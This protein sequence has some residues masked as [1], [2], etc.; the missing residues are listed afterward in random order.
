MP[1]KL[2]ILAEDFRGLH[3]SLCKDLDKVPNQATIALFYTLVNHLT[4][5]RSKYSNIG[6]LFYLTNILPHSLEPLQ[7]VCVCTRHLAA[8][9]YILSVGFRWNVRIPPSHT[10]R[11][12][13]SY[14]YPYFSLKK[15]KI[16]IQDNQELCWKWETV[17]LLWYWANLF[18]NILIYSYC[19]PGVTLVQ[20]IVHLTSRQFKG[21]LIYIASSVIM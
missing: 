3:Q 5:R 2:T 6:I 18:R 13:S 15:L 4:T 8:A 19:G 21:T 12:L 10:W 9:V 1:T 14:Y 11:M 20:D 7:L 17:F 16:L